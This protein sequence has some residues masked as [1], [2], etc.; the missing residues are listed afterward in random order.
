MIPLY[1]ASYIDRLFA[2]EDLDSI[3]LVIS[4]VEQTR[5]LPEE[6]WLYRRI[7]EWAPVRSGVGQYYEGLSEANFNRIS[8]GLDRFGLR[9]I[10][11][12]FRS[13][14]D[15]WRDSKKIAQLDA[16]LAANSRAIHAAVFKLI[17]PHKDLL[18]R[19]FLDE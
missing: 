2:D 1:A 5:L 9:E 18:F 7:Y 4:A 8:S 3:Y 17:R 13:G 19:A 15:T 16:W 12:F 10:A 14:R 11:T 6:F